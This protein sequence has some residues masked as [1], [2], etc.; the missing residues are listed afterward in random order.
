MDFYHSSNNSPSAQK[1][2]GFQVFA[3]SNDLLITY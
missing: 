1:H 3:Y 2:L